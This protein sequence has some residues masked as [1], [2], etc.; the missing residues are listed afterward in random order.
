MGQLQGNFHLATGL[1][2]RFYALQGRKL[3]FCSLTE[4]TV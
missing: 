3:T 4:M 2:G 1:V